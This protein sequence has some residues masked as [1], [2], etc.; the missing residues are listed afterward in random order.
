MRSLVLKR[1]W[2]LFG[3]QIIFAVGA[4]GAFVGRL[5]NGLGLFG[6]PI[7]I[8]RLAVA[9]GLA[10]NIWFAAAKMRCPGCNRFLGLGLHYAR[11]CTCGVPIR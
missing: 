5:S 11:V 10:A 1:R 2:Q 3:I 6:L 4:L 7:V 8:W 9:L